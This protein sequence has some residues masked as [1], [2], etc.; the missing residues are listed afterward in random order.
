[1]SKLT[2]LKA[3]RKKCLDWC[4]QQTVEARECTCTK[5]PLFAYRMG[6]RPKGKED[7]ADSS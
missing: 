3:I 6:K 2:P 7:I 4:C 1:M 5:C